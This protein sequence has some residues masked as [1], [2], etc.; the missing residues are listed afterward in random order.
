MVFRICEICGS[1]AKNVADFNDNVL[2]AEHSDETINIEE[3][4]PPPPAQSREMRSF[5]HGHRFLNFMLACV[6]F[7]F[8]ISWMFHFNMPH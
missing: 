2:V 3:P 5:W 4:P 6:V 1:T 8:V 7:A